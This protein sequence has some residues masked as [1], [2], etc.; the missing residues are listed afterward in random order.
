MRRASLAQAGFTIIETMIFLAVTGGMI[1]IVLTTFNGRISNAQFSQ[2]VNEFDTQLKGVLN[3]VSAGTF[4]TNPPFTCFVGADKN[5][6]IVSSASPDNKQG[7]NGPCI[8]LGK[9]L[10]VGLTNAPS[11]FNVYTVAG[12]RTQNGLATGMDVTMVAGPDGAQPQIIDLETRQYQVDLTSYRKL[13]KGLKAAR[14]V[15][16]QDGTSTTI[17]AIGVFQTLG[18]YS[19]G[20]ATTNPRLSPGAQTLQIWP[21][22]EGYPLSQSDV[23]DAVADHAVDKTFAPGNANP[24]GGITICL[25]G[26]NANQKADITL[27][28]SAGKVSTTVHFGGSPLCP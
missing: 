26:G 23:H 25:D 12:S 3:D 7:T 19:T 1:T 16:T 18:S 17:G 6:R 8:F 15:K 28:G 4:P 2:A 9:V 21:I 20:G 13:S 27:G 5:P 14:I 10:Q 24:N 11:G 22:G